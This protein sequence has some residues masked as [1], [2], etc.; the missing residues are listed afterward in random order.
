[1]KT[2]DMVRFRIV[3]NHRDEV[4]STWKVGILLEYQSWEKI[5]SVLSTL[6]LFAPA[7]MPNIIRATGDTVLELKI[8]IFKL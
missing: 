3:L 8:L 7:S 5:A 1:M 4:L 6:S 2:G